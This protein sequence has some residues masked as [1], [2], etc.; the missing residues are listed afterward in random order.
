MVHPVLYFINTNNLKTNRKI[1]II[2]PNQ[3][4]RL[5]LYLNCIILLVQFYKEVYENEF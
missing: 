1:P 5:T 2:Y 3:K 4:K